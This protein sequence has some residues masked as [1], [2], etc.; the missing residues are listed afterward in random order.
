MYLTFTMIEVK[1]VCCQKTENDI[2]LLYSAS[3]EYTN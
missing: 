2:N 3:Q 1:N